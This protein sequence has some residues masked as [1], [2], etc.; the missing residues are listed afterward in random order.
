M[1]VGNDQVARHI[2]HRVVVETTKSEKLNTVSSLRRDQKQVL[3][4]VE[5]PIL[6]RL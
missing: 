1:E 2:L 3:G 6:D 4:V 5:K